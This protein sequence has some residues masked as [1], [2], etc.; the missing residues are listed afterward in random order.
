M[1]AMDKPQLAD[2]QNALEQRLKLLK[3]FQKKKLKK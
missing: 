3:K 1:F 2:F